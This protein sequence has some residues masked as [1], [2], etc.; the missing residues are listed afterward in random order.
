[1]LRKLIA[2]AAL[3]TLSACASTTPQTTTA[4][5]IYTPAHGAAMT[6]TGAY[7]DGVLTVSVDD[8]PSI[9]GVMPRSGGTLHGQHAGRSV[10]AV[11]TAGERH[12]GRALYNAA[13]TGGLSL[14]HDTGA[15]R[16]FCTVAIAGERA[17]TLTF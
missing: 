2:G 15:G 10:D 6:V 11:C 12:T 17:V 8:A 16:L 4:I 13:W 3:A 5:Q 7:S 9:Q 1:M 14:L